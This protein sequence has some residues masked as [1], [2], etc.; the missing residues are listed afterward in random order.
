MSGT[1]ASLVCLA[2]SSALGGAETSLLTLLGALRR[3]EPRWRM[4]VVAPCDGPLLDRCRAAGIAVRQLP[5]PGA[6]AAMGE[7]AATGARRRSAN[8]I[9][10]VRHGAGALAALPGYLAALRG[11]L[12]ELDATI[13]HTNGIKAHVAAALARPHGAR[14]VWHL[15][16][17]VRAR[18][19]TTRLLQVLGRRADVL[20]A[21]SDSVLS[22]ARAAFGP[23]RVIRRIYNAVDLRTFAPDGETLD[24]AA[25]A[26]MPSDAGLLRVGLLATFGRWKGHDVFLDALARVPRPFR[27]YI[28]GGPVYATAGSQWSMEELWSRVAALG[29]EDAV[30]FTG[31]VKDVAAAMRSLDI[32]VHA[33]TQPEPFGMVIAEGMATGR[34][35][36]AVTAGGAAELFEDRRTAVGVPPHDAAALAARIQEL[37]AD[38]SLRARL[39]AAAREAA[40]RMFSA[41]RMAREFREVY[42]G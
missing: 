2:T 34:S 22:D 39:G 29:L 41:D 37:G 5:F 14:L 20:V 36:I 35:V 21:N 30:G 26:G 6:L 19:V 12:Q 17:Y 40:C 38:P 32:V 42:A 28:V 10:L 16:E 3:L 33:S 8:Q 13:V 27:A 9:A 4:A 18:P 11:T 7:S 24:L 23:A 1:P 15:H 25:L 31:H